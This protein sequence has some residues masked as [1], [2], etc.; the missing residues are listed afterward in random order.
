MEAGGERLNGTS[1]GEN[2]GTDE[3]CSLSSNDV[4][5]TAS[6]DGRNLQG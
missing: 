5:H 6:G 4:A 1:N 3:E 2:E